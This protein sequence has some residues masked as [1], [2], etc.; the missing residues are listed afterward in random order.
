MSDGSGGFF[1]GVD[2]S[3]MSDADW[4]NLMAGLNTPN[5]DLT[6]GGTLSPDETGGVGFNAPGLPAGGGG[7]PGAGGG[8]IGSILQALGLGTAG[9]GMNLPLLLSMLGAGVGGF[10]NKSAT[11]TATDQVLQS[12]KD[13]NTQVTGILG[14]GGGAQQSIQPYLAGGAA[15]MQAAPGMIYKPAGSAFTSPINANVNLPPVSLAAIMRKGK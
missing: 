8:G 15:A 14:P 1:N 7:L 6:S 4:S 12:I 11:G 9:G 10:M 3:N 5:L 13:A 2:L